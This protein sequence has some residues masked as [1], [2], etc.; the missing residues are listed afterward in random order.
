MLQSLRYQPAP[1]IILLDGFFVVI[2]LAA[3][4]NSD[5]GL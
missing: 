2:Q 1:L 4:L 5:A 3:R